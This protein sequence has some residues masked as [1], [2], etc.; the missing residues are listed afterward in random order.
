M[1]LRRHQPQGVV[2]EPVAELGT[3]YRRDFREFPDTRAACEPPE[4]ETS[5]CDQWLAV[6]VRAEIAKGRQD[7]RS[8][9]VADPGPWQEPLAVWPRRKPLDGLIEPQLWFGQGGGQVVGQGC[10]CTL[11][12]PV[13]V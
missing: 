13:G 4:S 8:G 10:D 2:R 9:G 3:A 1:R 11:I 7:G 5:P 12:D 6:G